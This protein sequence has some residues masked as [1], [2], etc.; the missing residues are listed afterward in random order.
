MH[1]NKISWSYARD[2]EHRGGW[3]VVLPSASV[4]GRNGTPLFGFRTNVLNDTT[5]YGLGF[6]AK[7]FVNVTTSKIPQTLDVFLQALHDLNNPQLLHSGYMANEDDHILSNYED[8]RFKATIMLDQTKCKIFSATINF[9]LVYTANSYLLRWRKSDIPFCMQPCSRMMDEMNHDKLQRDFREIQGHRRRINQAIENF[10]RF[11]TALRVEATFTVSINDE[12]MHEEYENPLLGIIRAVNTIYGEWADVTIVESARI[13]RPSV[14]PGVIKTNSEALCSL[15]WP[16]LETHLMGNYTNIYQKEMVALIERML[17]FN[18]TGFE[19][20]LGYLHLCIDLTLLAHPMF[21]ACGLKHF[22]LERGTHK[23]AIVDLAGLSLISTTT[24]TT[25]ISVTSLTLTPSPITPIIVIS[26]TSHITIISKYSITNPIIGYPYFPEDLIE[27]ESLG[28]S[29]ITHPDDPLMYR[30]NDNPYYGSREQTANPT[31]THLVHI[32][33]DL[34]YTDVRDD[35]DGEERCQ[36]Y[37][38][39][40]ADLVYENI[41]PQLARYSKEKIS[42]WM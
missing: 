22:Y 23:W 30:Y 38:E 17:Y 34:M 39:I 1:V 28:L 14:F 35:I 42:D 25:V 5:L 33:M 29:K 26:V 20:D 19:K 12:D 13:V 37:Q 32:C 16:I 15:I 18:L 9:T 3:S 11:G 8:L 21:T 36:I 10:Y 7:N 41:L 40:F 4:T 24:L 2:Y 6:Q 31:H 27:V